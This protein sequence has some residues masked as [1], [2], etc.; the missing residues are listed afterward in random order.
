[1]SNP[2]NVKYTCTIKHSYFKQILSLISAL[3]DFYDNENKSMTRLFYASRI[4]CRWEMRKQLCNAYVKLGLTQ[5]ALDEF[6]GNLNRRNIF[7]CT[8]GKVA[9]F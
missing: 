5:A 8:S 9:F 4:T 1:M 7:G 6:I 3:V 2:L